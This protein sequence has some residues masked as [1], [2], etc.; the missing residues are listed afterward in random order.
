MFEIFRPHCHEGSL[1]FEDLVE[2]IN[3]EGEVT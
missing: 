1:Q 2:A 3:V